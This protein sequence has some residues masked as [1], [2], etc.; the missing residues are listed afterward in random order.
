M[1]NTAMIGLAMVLVGGVCQALF[2]LPA[3]WSKNWNFEHV[4]LTFSFFCYF[5]IP[6][7][8]VFLCVPSVKA[9]LSATP[10]QTLLMMGVYATGWA[11][12]AL[13]FGIGINIVGLSLGFAIIY[14]LAAFV[15]A[16]V[17]LLTSHHG[18]LEKFFVILFCLFLMLL[19]V[20]FCSFAGRWREQN[21]SSVEG[22]RYLRGVIFCIVSGLLGATG[23]M[24]FVAGTGMADVAQA[25]GLSNFAGGS[26]V[27]A[28]LCLFM[29]V[30]NGGYAVVLLIRNSSSD[31]L[32][33]AKHSSYFIFSAL[34]GLF[35]MAGFLLYGLGARALGELGHSLG[36][37]VLM[38]T[39]VASANA[40]GMLSG[41]WRSAPRSAKRQLAAGIALLI[42]AMAGLAASNAMA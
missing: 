33:T 26:L 24:G 22:G 28:Y 39:V 41:E 10:S 35:W 29:F 6:W 31:L 20:T 1:D 2:M 25:Q 5:L 42:F 37:G 27:L 3:K 32:L 16:L 18:S 13:S 9:V 21:A 30:F 15:G 34:M 8:I 12:A 14:G 40:I 7:L 4:W 38:C 19:G 23:N 11:L 36:W 17:P